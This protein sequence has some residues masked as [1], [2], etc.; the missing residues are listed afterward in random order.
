MA[1][2]KA[3][4]LFFRELDG[5]VGMCFSTALRKSLQLMPLERQ[6]GLLPVMG[7]WLMDS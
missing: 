1:L 6:R 2:V 5:E 4:A 3:S 7:S